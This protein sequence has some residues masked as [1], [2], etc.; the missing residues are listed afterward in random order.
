MSPIS[1]ASNSGGSLRERSDDADLGV[2]A[3]VL[4]PLPNRCVVAAKAAGRRMNSKSVA[5]SSGARPR[6]STRSAT[7]CTTKVPRNISRK[8]NQGASTGTP[9]DMMVAAGSTT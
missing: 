2:T 5:C 8:V 7:R 4:G 9:P 3:N 6:D 1:T